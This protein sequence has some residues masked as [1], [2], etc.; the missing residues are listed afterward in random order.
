MIRAA[1]VIAHNPRAS[2]DEEAALLRPARPGFAVMLHR[3]VG[4]VVRANGKEYPIGPLASLGR[5]NHA[6]PQRD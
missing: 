2:R 6:I 3:A 5:R 4:Q 1:Q